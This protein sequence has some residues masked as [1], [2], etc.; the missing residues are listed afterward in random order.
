MSKPLTPLPG[1]SRMPNSRLFS[2]RRRQPRP[3]SQALPSRI[4]HA[5]LMGCFVS[6]VVWLALAPLSLAFA[7]I[8][9]QG[10]G[11]LDLPAMLQ[12]EPLNMGGNVV[13]TRFGLADE[14]MAVSSSDLML[15]VLGIAVL[16]IAGSRLRRVPVRH[17]VFAVC[18]LHLLGT[19]VAWLQGD[20]FPHN[21]LT[22]TRLVADTNLLWLAL[23]PIMLTLGFYVVE[24]S[25][26]NRVLATALF[27][28]WQIVAL[29]LKVLL[30]AVLIQALTPAVIPLLFVATG[31]MLDVLLMAA[32][33]AWCM[34]WPLLQ[35]DERGRLATRPD[36]QVSP[37]K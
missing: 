27:I 6:L 1:S 23:S 14:P 34:T 30:S 35:L 16:L 32:L 36:L 13:L 33:Y 10:A 18:A 25:W 26:V 7:D 21:M 22:H 5:V 19:G 2:T 28:G 37:P 29:P 20:A 8:V 12:Q 15:H 3:N 17:A 4:L 31:P 9:I 24:R 11:L